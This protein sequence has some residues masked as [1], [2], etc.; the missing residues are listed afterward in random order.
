MCRKTIIGIFLLIAG[1]L[2]AQE[3]TT[4]PYS[5]Y[6]IGNLKFRGTVE[7]RTMGGI[8][9]FSD[10]IHLNL[11]NPAGFAALKLV[12]F[13]IGAGQ[14]T[15]KQKNAD[16]GQNVSTSSLEYLAIGVPMGKMRLGFGIMPNSTVGYH[17]YS[18]LEN[19]R[20]E[21]YGNGG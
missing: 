21:Y 16:R 11:Q 7:D 9:V 5:F 17:F 14:K 1:S 18:D 20:S 8:G 15:S 13:S 4:S 2:V 12:N 19:G 6:G 3:G 10:S